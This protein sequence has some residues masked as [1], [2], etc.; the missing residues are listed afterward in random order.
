MD[1]ILSAME[2]VQSNYTRHSRMAQAIAK[3]YFAA[4]TVLGKLVR[5]LGV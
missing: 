5:D 1:D 2:A 4:E 3:Q